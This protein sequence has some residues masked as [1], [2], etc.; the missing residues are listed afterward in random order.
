MGFTEFTEALPLFTQ[1]QIHENLENK[2]QK[3][4]FRKN[5]LERKKHN[6]EK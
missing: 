4:V 5:N 6:F 3:I 1:K 2:F